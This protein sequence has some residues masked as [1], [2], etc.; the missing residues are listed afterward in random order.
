M[1]IRKHLT[2][3]YRE[4]VC[5][6]FPCQQ[7]LVAKEFAFTDYDKIL[8]GLNISV[9]NVDSQKKLEKWFKAQLQEVLGVSK[10]EDHSK[11]LLCFLLDYLYPN[12][13]SIDLMF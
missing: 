12:S 3:K 9:R 2:L 4:S 5:T 1:E 8:R 13:D 10:H 11:R 6:C 7:H